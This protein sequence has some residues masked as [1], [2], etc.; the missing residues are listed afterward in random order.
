MV[1]LTLTNKTDLCENCYKPAIRLAPSGSSPRLCEAKPACAGYIRFIAALRYVDPC[2]G[3]SCGTRRPLPAEC[4]P[5]FISVAAWGVNSQECSTLSIRFNLGENCYN[6]RS[7]SA[8]SHPMWAGTPGFVEQSSHAGGDARTPPLTLFNGRTVTPCG[9]G[10]PRT[11]DARG[12]IILPIAIILYLYPPAVSPCG[13]GRP[14]T[15]DAHGSIILHIAIIFISPHGQ[16]Q[17]RLIRVH[18]SQMAGI[19]GSH[20]FLE[21][22]RMVL[23]NHTLQT[24]LI[25]SN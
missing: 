18:T 10:R 22:I 8:R 17:A 23:W 6:V 19:M 1:C 5:K 14:R 13:R 25:V 12:S 9:R 2:P 11:Q 16:G 24:P 3:L 4:R 7:S 20:R 21:Q 15:Q